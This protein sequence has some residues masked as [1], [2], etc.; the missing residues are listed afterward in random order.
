MRLAVVTPV[1]GRHDHLA[2]QRRGLERGRRHPDVHVVVAMAD[3][4]VASAIDGPLTTAVHHV[5]RPGGTLP[6]AYAR[7]AGAALA[8]DGGADV[9]VFLDVDCVPSAHL[10]ARYAEVAQS[11]YGEGLLCGAVA[12]LPPPPT[13]GYRIDDLPYGA[14]GHPGRPVAP[15]DGVITN[16]PHELFWSLSFAVTRA[17]W[18]AAGGF[19][20]TYIGYGGEDTDFGQRA[21][22]IGI[23]LHWIGGAWAY[24][25]F[26][27]TA[28][29]PTQ[30]VDDILRNS[31]IF[32]RKWGWWP[33]TGWLQAFRELGLV[34][35][36][37]VNDTW[38]RASA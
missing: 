15:E 4:D 35:H 14:A 26:H 5:G 8:L 6:L 37:E 18:L 17:T 27:P 16:G 36:D 30:H 38:S 32:R 12:Y 29:P 20:E 33:M 28:D 1:A 25:Q 19:D 9:L 21:K 3:P 11:S 31:A 34:S 2:M 13:G 22:A 24:H 10:I 7:N 23:P